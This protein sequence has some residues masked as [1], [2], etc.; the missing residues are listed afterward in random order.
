[1]SSQPTSAHR[2]AHRVQVSTPNDVAGVPVTPDPNNPNAAQAFAV[3]CF[4][5]PLAPSAVAASSSQAPHSWGLATP[6]ATATPGS[7]QNNA[8]AAQAAPKALTLLAPKPMI[9]PVKA[10][11]LRRGSS[12][13]GTALF[14]LEEEGATN[15]DLHTPGFAKRLKTTGPNS[16]FRS[17][18]P[19]FQPYLDAS[20]GSR[21]SVGAGCASPWASPWAVSELASAVTVEMSPLDVLALSADASPRAKDSKD[22][23]KAAA[24]HGFDAKDE[25]ESP[26][27]LAAAA[28]ASFNEGYRQGYAF[29]LQGG[30]DPATAAANATQ[31]GSN[32]FGSSFGAHAGADGS[33]LRPWGLIRYDTW[34]SSG[35]VGF[36]D[37]PFDTPWPV[38]PSIP[39][40][41]WA[42]HSSSFEGTPAHSSS[43]GGGGGGGQ[44]GHKTTRGGRRPFGKVSA[45]THNFL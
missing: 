29:G 7:S 37:Q 42:N 26:E 4:L 38:N 27:R 23:A 21:E 34:A 13:D 36:G 31:F 32:F 6:W 11:G 39:C 16:P 9:S 19:A 14:A 43:S 35:G 45:P 17:L 28:I 44:Q 20:E 2:S 33:M 22:G 30:V 18:R 3:P 10:L 1:V 24:E 40:T 15:L 5:S 12:Y 8:A 25:D 41:V